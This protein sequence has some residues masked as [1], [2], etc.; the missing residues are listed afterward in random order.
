MLKKLLFVLA[1]FSLLSSAHAAEDDPLPIPKSDRTRPFTVGGELDFAS[2]YVWRGVAYSTGPVLQ[3]SAWISTHGFTFTVWNNVDLTDEPARSTYNELDLY[4]TYRKTWKKISFE[5]SLN[6]YYY[7][8]QHLAGTAELHFNFYY[9]LGPVDLFTT[10]SVDIV[11]S[12][13]AYFGEF[14]L[15]FERKFHPKISLKTLA[16]FGWANGRFNQVTFG[17]DRAA[18]NLFSYN[19]RFL[20]YPVKFFYLRPHLEFTALL[21]G[22]LR[23][24]VAHPTIV[25]GG[26]AVG[27]NF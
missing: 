25:S 23:K 22:I 27:L 15:A 21:D 10:Q 5:P 17:I 2:R 11:E 19:L 1:I 13:G 14:G 16:S 4:F 20:Y 3:P 9:S 8:T 6:I 7:P 18:L 24:Q 12:Q 26:L